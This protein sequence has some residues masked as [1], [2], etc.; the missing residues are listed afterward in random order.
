MLKADRCHSEKLKLRVHEVSKPATH[1]E[2]TPQPTAEDKNIRV[3][4][5]PVQPNDDEQLQ[6]NLQRK[7][8]RSSSPPSPGRQA[9]Q[10]RRAGAD[11]EAEDVH[12]SR[13]AG[14]TSPIHTGA[15]LDWLAR[16]TDIPA[17]YGKRADEWRRMVISDMF[18]GGQPY[19]PLPYVGSDPSR[20][21]WS[22]S[23]AW[24]ISRL[25][26]PSRTQT[27][28]SYLVVGPAVRGKFHPDKV[29][30]LGVPKGAMWNALG[31]NESVTL[32]DGR[33][34]EPASCIDP[35]RPPSVR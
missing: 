33:V 13:H 6:S 26:E 12:A 16:Q 22:A 14:K 21:K 7:R 25:P 28:L 2:G 19:P 23:P 34:I 5:F 11:G 1:D 10:P 18:R 24:N 4:A 17:L 31:R 32:P 15:P 9:K 30:A 35:T 20:A 8:S 3:Y 29:V 27:A